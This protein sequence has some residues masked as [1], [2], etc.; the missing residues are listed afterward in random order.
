[1]ISVFNVSIIETVIVPE[2]VELV[3]ATSITG[4][5]GVVYTETF[6]GIDAI[7]PYGFEARTESEYVFAMSGI[8]A[9]PVSDTVNEYRV[10]PLLVI[11]EFPYV[12][13][14]SNEYK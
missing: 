1:L 13:P 7:F 14:P 5:I 12:R 3:F 11:P 2:L 6:V 8:W 10:F 9:F 4:E